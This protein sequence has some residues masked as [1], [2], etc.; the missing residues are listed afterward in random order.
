MRLPKIL[1]FSSMY[2]NSLKPDMGVFIHNQVRSLI[3]QGCDAIVVSPI[4]WVP[5]WLWWR[6]KWN[7]YRNI[8]KEERYDRVKVFRPRYFRTPGGQWVYPWEGISM[9]MGCKSLV[10]SLRRNSEF[11]IIHAHRIIP[12]GHA[13]VLLAKKLNV[14]VVCS[15]RG[16]ET[17]K[18]PFENPLSY[19][20]F[21]KVLSTCDRIITV[22]KA[23][24]DVVTNNVVK[25]TVDVI[26]NGCD[27]NTFHYIDKVEARKKLNLPMDGKIFLFVG[28]IITAKGVLDL[29]KAFHHLKKSES[30]IF[31]IMIGYGDEVVNIQRGIKIRNLSGSVLMPGYMPQESLP[32]WINASDIFVFP[33]YQ[34]GLPN[35]VL[36][37]MA[38]RKPVIATRVGGIPEII[39]DGGTGF[40][41][42]PRNIH[43]LVEAM[44]TLLENENLCSTLGLAAERFVKQHFTWEKSAESLINVYQNLLLN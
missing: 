2:P 21:K 29:L 35:A 38:C 16:G 39:S 25:H 33:S 8:E 15:A 31:L 44:R 1:I 36:E 26:Y 20:S 40:L 42:E 3:K 9:Y 14:P 23:L 34:E 43:Q 6:R 10:A 41:V 17:Y 24:R 22:S 27:V 37:A 19:L 7:G 32:L 18:L 30:S 28:H 4:P 13:A 12:D 11:D 5:G